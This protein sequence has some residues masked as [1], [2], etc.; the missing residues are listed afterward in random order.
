MRFSRSTHPLA[1]SHEWLV[2]MMW[3]EKEVHRLDTEYNMWT[4]SLTSPMTMTLDFSRSNFE[5]A[6]SQELLVWLM[7]N[8][9]EVNKYDTGPTVCFAFW[10]H[11]WLWP[12][13]FKVAVWNSLIC[14]MWRPI[15][16]ERKGC[17]S[18]IHD[19][20]ITFVWPCWG[21]W[22]YRIVTKVISDVGVPST[23]LV[24]M[25][26]QVLESASIFKYGWYLWFRRHT[27][28]IAGRKCRVWLCYKTGRCPMHRCPPVTNC[29]P[30]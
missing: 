21:G 20:D 22:M 1:I 14:G 5:I 15:D 17:E 27:C 29:P 3:N 11:P 18:S 16:M 7:W 10:P 28:C 24:G 8:E 13:S 25:I 6:L 4:W 9:K 30:G 2:R 26:L 12:W 23:Y 19:H